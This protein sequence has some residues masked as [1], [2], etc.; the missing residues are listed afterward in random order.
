MLGLMWTSSID[1]QFFRSYTEG[2][3]F[4]GASYY[5]GELNPRQHFYDPGMALGGFIKHNFTEHHCLRVGA[6]FGQLKGNDLESKNEYQRMRAHSFDTSLLDFHVGYEFN[7]MP[8][9][10][11]RWKKAH[12]PYIFGAIGY[13][14]I[15]SSTTDMAAS[16]VTI[17]FGVG[18][19]YRFSD[20]LAIGCEWGMRK[21]FT[22]TVDGILNPGPDGTYSASHNND[23]YSFAGVYVTFR[24]FEK[25]FECPGVKEEK[26]YR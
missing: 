10:I 4:A 5:L 11:N 22:D 26:K 1:G 3:V 19:K 17:P 14:L 18:Y 23:W 9:V 13:S 15:L 24:L 12:S 8:Y 16:H 7:F 2:G 25:K 20:S 6:F 21:S